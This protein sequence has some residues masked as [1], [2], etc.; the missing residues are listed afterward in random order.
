MYPR[1]PE[2]KE[3]P[4]KFPKLDPIQP[5]AG[6]L[7]GYINSLKSPYEEPTDY[8]EW[9][10]PPKLHVGAEYYNIDA[11][12]N[13]QP[14]MNI[15]F[16]LYWFQAFNQA[17]FPNLIARIAAREVPAAFLKVGFGDFPHDLGSTLRK[18]WDITPLTLDQALNLR[19]RVR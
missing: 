18:D 8:V 10:I 6:N 4:G 9:V 11:N 17:R 2:T 13:H 3:I 12:R 7:L 1:F 16:A 5:A 15:L 19:G 14:V